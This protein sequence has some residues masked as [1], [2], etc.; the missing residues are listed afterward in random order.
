MGIRWWVCLYWWQC[1]IKSTLKGNGNSE[2]Q[3]KTGRLNTYISKS[4][5]NNLLLAPVIKKLP[6]IKNLQKSFVQLLIQETGYKYRYIINVNLVLAFMCTK[7]LEMR[8]ELHQLWDIGGS[9]RHSQ[10]TLYETRQAMYV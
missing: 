2:Y 4:L 7:Y 5:Q 6:L 8:K 3:Y 9:K 10:K 1:I